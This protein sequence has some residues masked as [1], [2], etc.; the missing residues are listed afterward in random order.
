MM[1]LDMV[2]KLQELQELKR[3]K[4]ELDAAIEALQDDVKA[5]MCDTESAVFGPFK[6]TYKTVIQNRIDSAALKKELPEVAA[7]YSKPVTTRP[8]K[9][10]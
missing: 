2:K 3:M 5:A 8:L 4:E 6:V 10:S 9:V 7:R 1:N